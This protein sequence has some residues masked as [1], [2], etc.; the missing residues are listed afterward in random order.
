YARALTVLLKDARGLP[1][2]TRNLTSTRG[3]YVGT[4]V[5][6]VSLAGVTYEMFNACKPHE[7]SDSRVEV[8]FAP[9]GTQFWAGAYE[10]DNPI[11]WLGV[12]SV[13]QQEAMKGPLQT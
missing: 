10:G 9:N 7:C 13:A 3:N 8:M 1:Q 11:V 12:P 6:Y 4:P 5:E 2:W